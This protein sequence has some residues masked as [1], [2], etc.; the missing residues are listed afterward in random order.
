M[1]VD[2]TLE[3]DSPDNLDTMLRALGKSLE[4]CRIRILFGDDF[5]KMLVF[6]DSGYTW[7]FSALLVGLGFHRISHFFYMKT[8]SEWLR[9][10]S[11]SH[12]FGVCFAR[13]VQD[14][15]IIWEMTSGIFRIL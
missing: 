5:R 2:L 3:V 4:K 1:L 7:P 11:G 15:W 10:V 6:L 8:D 12:V 14:C 9:V 13:G